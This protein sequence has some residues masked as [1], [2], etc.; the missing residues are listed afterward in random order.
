MEPYKGADNEAR[1]DGSDCRGDPRGG[2]GGV[3]PEA[4]L[5]GHVDP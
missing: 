3:G 4:E 2:N 5:L 1:T